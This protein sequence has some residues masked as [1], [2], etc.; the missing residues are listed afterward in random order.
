MPP[1]RFQYGTQGKP[2]PTLTD[3]PHPK[4]QFSKDAM[5]L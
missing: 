5:S 2:D 1:Y 3:C 4:W